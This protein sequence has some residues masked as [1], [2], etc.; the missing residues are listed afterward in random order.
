M[1]TSISNSGLRDNHTRGTV[2]EFL[3]DKIHDGSK[4][5]VVSAYFTVYVYDVLIRKALASIEHTFQRR[6][7]TSLLSRRSARLPSAAEVPTSRGE[8]FDLVTWLVNVGED[9]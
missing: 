6:A 3:A 2:A 9:A 4:L 5:S 8:D 7:A 1:S